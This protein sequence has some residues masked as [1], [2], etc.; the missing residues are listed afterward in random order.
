MC[1]QSPQNKFLGA[2][3]Y[4]SLNEEPQQNKREPLPQNVSDLHPSLFNTRGVNYSVNDCEAL[5]PIESV[6][7]LH[8]SHNTWLYL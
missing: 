5:R 2:R 3:Y 4:T 1:F 7:T 8:A 6:H